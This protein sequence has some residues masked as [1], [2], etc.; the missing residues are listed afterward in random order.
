MVFSTL[1]DDLQD[2][3]TIDTSVKQ[4]VQGMYDRNSSIFDNIFLMAFVL[5]WG[6]TLLF[7]YNLDSNPAFFVI[8]LIV[9]VILLIT[10]TFLGNGVT[11]MLDDPSISSYASAFP[12]TTYITSN[13]LIV[14]IVVGFSILL[15]LY[16]G[17]RRGA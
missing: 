7:A 6:A 11:E 15:V 12:I 2:D 1:N 4:E 3:A 5:L 17:Q 9:L 14:A 13:L 16:T 8:A 10:S